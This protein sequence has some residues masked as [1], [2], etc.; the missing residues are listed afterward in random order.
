MLPPALSEQLCNLLPGH[1]RLAFSVILTLDNDAKVLKKSFSK[2]ILRSAARLAYSDV[3]RVLDG[4]SIGDALVD[5]EHK[6]SD[7]EQDILILQSLANRLMAR[8]FRNGA[9][10]VDIPALTFTLEDNGRPSDCGQDHRTDTE[11]LLKEFL[12][13]TNVTVAQQIVVHLPEQ[14]LLH[15]HDTPLERRLNNLAQRAERL[16]Y[17][18]DV[19][20]AGGLMKS[21]N[22]IPNTTA[23]NLLEL[24]SFKATNRAKYFCSGMLDIAK[25]GHYALN[26]PLYT[27]FTSPLRRYADIL[28]HRQLE[29]VLQGGSEVKFAMDRDA[30]A[31]V[32]QQCNIKRDSAVLAQE[33]S[34]HLFLCVLI[35]DLTTRY[36]PVIRPATVVG[37]LEAAFDVL[38]PEFGIEKRVHV[39]QMPIDNH[40]YDEHLHT[41]QI[42]WSDKDVISWLVD[43]SDDEHLKK[44]KQNAEQHAVKMEVA[45]RSVH[46]EKALFD[47]DDDDDVNGDDDEIVLGRESAPVAAPPAPETSKQKLYSIAKHQPQFEGLKVT[48]AGH[49][50]QEI[51][52]LM[53]VPVIV[54]ADLTKSPPVIKVYSVNP[55]AAKK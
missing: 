38:I 15:R 6:A 23:H 2:T 21:L 55:Y 54:T 3:Q 37:V 9:L 12:I 36:G 19:S 53:T 30:V 20:S 48:S 33:Q 44:V 1:D 4:Q 18:V 26:E 49:K 10:R 27:H 14:A 29:A 16:G 5:S 31:K 22:A 24:L 46:D 17:S 50:I 7:I 47:E 35:S 8:R 51:R 25:Y 41:L 39:D 52:E 34:A 11:S 32:A 40:V 42:Y 45:S 43:N 28:V 13:L